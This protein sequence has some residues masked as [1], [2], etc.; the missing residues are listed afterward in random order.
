MIGRLKHGT[1]DRERDIYKYHYEI[2]VD[3]YPESALHGP[4]M[5][6]PAREN[7]RADRVQLSSDS[8]AWR[9][10]VIGRF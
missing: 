1:F 3:D 10:M 5:S 6:A 7:G 8:I 4:I 2:R 9:C